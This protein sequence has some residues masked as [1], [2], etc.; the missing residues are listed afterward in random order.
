MIDQ[1][2]RLLAPLANRVA[3]IVT[4]AVV[5][6]VD[7]SKKLQELQLSVLD[8]EVR[9]E[10]EHFEPY[11]FTSSPETGAEVVAVCVGGRRDHTLAIGASDRR[12]RIRNLESGEVAIY[13]KHGQ[14][15]VLKANGD[16]ELNP[17]PGQVVA[18][19][20]QTN[21]IAKGDSLNSAI[22]TLATALASAISSI[23]AASP[24]SLTTS[25]TT[26]AIAAFNASAAAALS[27]KAKLS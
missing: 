22:N 20:G 25:A 18:V 5:K 16:I 26:A 21:P 7:A 8:G 10:V 1:L 13:S 15:I 3:N 12:Y 2:R 19:G 9:D 11:G 27:T 14:T 23:T 17:K 6:K 24:G 4:R